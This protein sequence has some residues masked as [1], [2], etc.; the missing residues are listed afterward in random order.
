MRKK[1]YIYLCFLLSCASCISVKTEL[2]SQYKE[3]V[4]AIN[5]MSLYVAYLIPVDSLGQYMYEEVISDDMY[6]HCE[7]AAKINNDR[8]CILG[9]LYFD[10]RGKV[11]K[12]IQWWSDGGDLHNVTYYNEQGNVIYAVYA[13]DNHN[14]G[15]LY[16]VGSKIYIEHSFSQSL[17]DYKSTFPD[18][19]TTTENL[20]ATYKVQ[21]Q[22]PDNCNNVSFMPVQK[23]DWVF[24]CTENIYATPK[25]EIIRNENENISTAWFGKLAR[26]D[27]VSNGW[28]KVTQRFDNLGYVAA[29][30][31]EL[32]AKKVS[33]PP[34]WCL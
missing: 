14:Y 27:S 2:D 32:S 28:C 24:L 34:F 25:G 15:R 18:L 21:L 4:K 7:L 22:M 17:Y 5:K 23:G 1:V 30:S 31:I 9:T 16:T 13:Y 29:D 26:I 3:Q 10:D 12:I 20:A 19:S 33:T 6:D 8:V 11:R